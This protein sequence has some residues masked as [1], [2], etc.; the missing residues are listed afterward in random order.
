MRKHRVNLCF[1]ETDTPEVLQAIYERGTASPSVLIH[2]LI[3]KGL[4]LEKLLTGAV[5]NELSS[6]AI[7]QSE[8]K[9]KALPSEKAAP[10]IV[11]VPPA[12]PEP[13][14]GIGNE[15]VVATAPKA[16]PVAEPP[17]VV[18]PEPQPER[19]VAQSSDDEEGAVVVS[20]SGLSGLGADY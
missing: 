16:A 15:A 1:N 17:P 5:L 2:D 3:R 18:A 10:E 4:I 6:L 14:V 12:K 9:G 19:H 7:A 11:A 8:G 20:M 13:V